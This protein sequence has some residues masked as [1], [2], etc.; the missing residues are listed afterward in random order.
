M[1]EHLRRLDLEAMSTD[2]KI[3]DV[4]QGGWEHEG[5]GFDFNVDHTLSEL[6]RMRSKDFYDPVVVKSEIA[7]DAVQYALRLARWTGYDLDFVLP[8]ARISPVGSSIDEAIAV[9][10]AKMRIISLRTAAYSA[11][12]VQLAGFTHSLDHESERQVALAN[13]F[14]TLPRVSQA[15]LRFALDS[16]EEYGFRV[17]VSFFDRLIALR[18]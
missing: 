15:L 14:D 8:G 5:K 16:G 13:K 18:E 11:S 1:S 6:V 9:H 12:E 7:P 10:A 2:L 4:D 3:Y 17:Q